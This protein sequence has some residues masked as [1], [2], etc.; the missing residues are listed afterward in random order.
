MLVAKLP[1]STYATAATKAGPRNGSSARRPRVSPS[2]ALCAASRTRC[3]P[4]S[5]VGAS[6]S[7]QR[8]GASATR[9]TS[10]RT[11]NVALHVQRAGQAQWDAF[12]PAFD[13]AFDGRFELARGQDL[14]PDARNQPATLELAQQRRILVRHALHAYFFPRFAVAERPV[15][16]RAHLARQARD[17]VPVRVQLRPAE[18]LED[19]G[20]HSLGDD[21]LEALRL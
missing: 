10:A 11:F 4:G 12:A 2:S 16:Q 17:G 13:S 14:D 3:S 6:S 18:E 20:L 21:V 8:S 15:A 5:A 9:R 19:P 1:G 7:T